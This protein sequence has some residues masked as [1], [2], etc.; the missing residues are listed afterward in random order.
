MEISI[1][2]SGAFSSVIV[3]LDPGE[4]FV[5]ESGAMYRASPNIDIDVTTR[6]RGKGGILAGVKRLLGK[7]HFYLSTYRVRNGGHGDAILLPVSSSNRSSTAGGNGAEPEMQLL[8]LLMSIFSIPGC[9]LIALKIA[10]T[11]GKRVT[12][13]L[14]V[15]L[16]MVEVSLGFGI[17]TTAAPT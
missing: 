4:S 16:I 9:W 12:R 6:S 11:P 15:F 10:G 17:S 1:N 7:E 2:D 14:E 8:T 5:S 3:Y 13:C